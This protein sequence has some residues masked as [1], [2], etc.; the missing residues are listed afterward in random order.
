MAVVLMG[1]PTTD[2]IIGGEWL[3][4]V[5]VLDANNCP[6]VDDTVEV[7]VTDP[8]AATTTPAVTNAGGG[9]YKAATYPAAA[10]R[11]SAAITTTYGA[12]AAVAYVA[13]LL[14]PPDVAALQTYLEPSSVETDRLEQALATETRAQRDVCTVPAEY[15]QAL[16]EAVLRRCAC[17]LARQGIPLAVV[18][19]DA[20]S[21]TSSVMPPT[22]DP[23][24][25]RLEGPYRKLPIG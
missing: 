10:G 14:E 21:G 5:Q 23:E 20:E 24:V 1:K 22:H 7:V 2:L 16:Y 8:S 11:W 3:L 19:G 25:R 13:E 17:N 6:V 18:Q 9:Y 15:A 12:A 4:C